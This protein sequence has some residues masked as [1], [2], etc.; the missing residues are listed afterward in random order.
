MIKANHNKYARAI[1]SIYLNRILK[2][3]FSHF[4]IVNEVTDINPDKALLVTPN[5]ISWWDGFFIDYINRLYFKRYFYIMMLEEQLKQYPY[6]SKVGAY[7]INPE[8]RK[9]IIESLEYTAELLSNPNNIVVMYPQGILEP[10]GKYPVTIKKGVKFVSEISRVPF[11]IIPFACKISFYNQ[12]KPEVYSRFSRL[13]SS[14]ALTESFSQY[15]KVFID[16]IKKVDQASLER[17]YRKDL[18]KWK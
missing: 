5:H 13:F 14:T 8:S 1:I 12:R 4:F 10:S 7:S 17:N 9:D 11:S 15:K 2:K 6:F 3:D 16:N 18:F